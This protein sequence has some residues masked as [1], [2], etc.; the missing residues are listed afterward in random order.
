MYFSSRNHNNNK[1]IKAVDGI[2]TADPNEW[3]R[4]VEAK[5]E[6]IH[7]KLR[8][9]RM[10]KRYCNILRK[11]PAP[12]YDEG[13]IYKNDNSSNVCNTCEVTKKYLD[14]SRFIGDKNE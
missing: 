9:A 7:C 10:H 14:V 4:Q 2:E 6:L 5:G 11:T 12:L 8:R 13:V 1:S 3:L